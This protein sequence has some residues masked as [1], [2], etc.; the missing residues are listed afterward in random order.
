MVHP[1][2]NTDVH[3]KGHDMDTKTALGAAGGI[4]LTVV[5]A[6]SALVLTFGGGTSILSG[7]PEEAPSQ[8]VVE[9]VDQYG[10]PVA[11][12]QPVQAGPE[13][14]VTTADAQAAD[15]TMV[16]GEQ[17]AGGEAYAEPGEE[18]EEEEDYAAG[19]LEEESEEYELEDADHEEDE[20]YG[21]GEHEEDDD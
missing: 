8:P 4:S 6:V 5:G 12:E 7:S 15:T 20:A 18:V 17:P 9:Y 13:I 2:I 11:L 1:D 19:E 10:N 3:V 21:A 14:V 16:A